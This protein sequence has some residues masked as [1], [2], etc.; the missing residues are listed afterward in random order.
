MDA[1]LTRRSAIQ[2]AG[3]AFAVPANH[4][5]PFHS[6]SGWM[7][8]T[9]KFAD[10]V[11]NLATCTGTGPVTLGQAVS[12]FASLSSAVSAGEQFYY[13]IQGVDRPQEREVGRGTMQ[14][15]GKIARQPIAGP[16]TNFSSG[17]KTI[18]LVAPA[19]WFARIEQIGGAAMPAVATRAEVAARPS[20][21]AY[22]AEAGRAGAFVFEASD[23]SAK[24]AADPTQAIYIPLASDASGASGAWIRRFDGPVNVRWFGAKGDGASNDGPAFLAAIAYLDATKLTGGFGYG[25]G[26]GELFVPAGHYYLG[27]STIELN[28]TMTLRGEAMGH[29]GGGSTVLRWAA[30]TTGIRVQAHNSI[31]STSFNAAPADNIAGSGSTIE[32]L[33]LKGGYAGADGEYHGIQLRGMATIRDVYVTGFQGDGIHAAASIGSGAGGQEG[34]VN[35]VRIERCTVE[36]CRRGLFLDGADSNA[37][38]IISCNFNCNRSWGVED[39][40]FIGNFYFGCHFAANGWVGAA[41]SVPT[42]CSHSGNRYFVKAGQAAGAAANPPSGTAADNAWWGYIGPG[43]AMSGISAW[44]SGTAFREGGAFKAVEASAPSLFAGIYTEG[45]QNPAQLVSPSL[46]VGGAHGAG[47]RGTAGVLQGYN[48]AVRA[49]AFKTVEQATG[50]YFGLGFQ[51]GLEINHASYGLY[52]LEW[53]GFSGGNLAFRYAHSD[54]PTHWPFRLTGQASTLN[55]GPHRMDFPSGFGLNDKKILSGTSPPASGA[56]VQG[57]TMF[58]AA[59]TAGGPM[60]WMCVAPGTPGTWKAMA[61][62]AS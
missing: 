42:A 50:S 3:A 17:A 1:K 5:L 7:P 51:Q 20:G 40:S 12:G 55:V 22:L 14:V 60:G 39:S 31:G 11:R 59:P 29:A 37:G 9:P 46:V 26:S 21:Q 45:D 16:L 25:A 56:Y 30:G 4:F 27:T 33:F 36:S 28:H 47:I 18:A 44:S 57:D 15:D 41:G 48:G 24:V 34:N 35:L 58:N 32:N 54:N 61:A 13:C 23:L 6:E 2:S 38:S 43:G 8:F 52:N 49:D 53:T 10:L 19:E 62:L